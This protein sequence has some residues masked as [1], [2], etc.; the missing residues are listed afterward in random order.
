[1]DNFS[2]ITA[3]KEALLKFFLRKKKSEYDIARL[4]YRIL[5]NISRFEKVNAMIAQETE[6]IASLE[7]AIKVAGIGKVGNKLM[8]WKEKSVQKLFK[9]NLRKDKI[10]VAKIV[11][12][13]SKLNGA[14]QALIEINNSIQN[15]E[16][17]ISEAAQPLA[18]AKGAA[19]PGEAIFKLWEKTKIDNHHNPIK[20]SINEHLNKFLKMAS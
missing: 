17:Q 3:L 18:E 5:A 14:R 4:E 13:Q 16:S 10:S 1:M 9:L 6:N 15:L 2:P 7:A 8:I 19:A 20:D 11:I 12:N